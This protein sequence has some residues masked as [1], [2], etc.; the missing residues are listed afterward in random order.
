MNQGG[1]HFTLVEM[2]ICDQYTRVEGRLPSHC[3][4]QALGTSQIPI[5]STQL[6]LS[7]RLLAPNRQRIGTCCKCRF[8]NTVEIKHLGARDWYDPLIDQ[9][10]PIRPSKGQSDVLQVIDHSVTG[11]MTA[12]SPRF[13]NSALRVATQG[14]QMA[15]FERRSYPSAE[16]QSAYSTALADR[17]LHYLVWS[18]CWLDTNLWV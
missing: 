7:H 11:S 2:G 14:Q 1:K 4:F 15:S 17:A 12:Q 18:G 16:V 10:G 9:I 6:S 13:R 5:L 3:Q 8:K